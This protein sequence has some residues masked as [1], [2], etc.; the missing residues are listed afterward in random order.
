LL[1]TFDTRYRRDVLR[2]FEPF[3]E[4]PA[5]A[6]VDSL[7]A[8]GFAFDAP[9][10]LMVHLTPPPELLPHGELPAE[11]VARARGGRE[12]IDACLG[13][14]RAFAVESGF[15]AFF[16]AQAEAYDAM[17]APARELTASTDYV[18]QL[19]TYF[20]ERQAEYAI[21]LAPLLAGNFGPRVRRRDGLH[22]YGIVSPFGVRDGALLFSTED[23]LRYLIWH[24]FGHSFVNPLAERSGTLDSTSSLLEPI[25]AK[26]RQRGYGNWR[27][28]VNEHIIRAVTARMEALH[29]GAERGAMA[30]LREKAN[31]FAYIDSLT[32]ALVGY[33]RQREQYPSLAAYYPELVAVFRRLSRL[34]LR[35]DFFTHPFIGPLDAVGGDSS[36]LIVLPSAEP[37]DSAQAALHQYV[38][39]MA[40]RFFAQSMIILDTTALAMDLSGH[41]LI[42]YGTLEGN[43]LLTRLVGALPITINESG[44]R[45]RELHEGA[46]LRLFSIWPSPWNA[47]RGVRIYSAQRTADIIGMHSVPH[48][49]TDYVIAKRTNVI[50]SG[51]YAGKLSGAWRLEGRP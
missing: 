35:P 33:E 48:G 18:G 27:T 40:A 45:A 19:E 38:R 47:N 13:H 10:H 21:V 29:F 34:D 9:H 7:V 2:Q 14:M 12:S 1:N 4:H 25:R 36:L 22:I 5:V 24:E 50:E 8:S 11:I 44:V 28:A 49:G 32:T 42:V 30:A 26:M 15:A 51:N 31:G 39:Q 41:E 43:R 3:R 6:C 46:G 20:G 23:R 16:A 17:A 37:D